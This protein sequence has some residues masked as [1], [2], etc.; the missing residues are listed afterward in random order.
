MFVSIDPVSTV[1]V[2]ILG[3][4]VRKLS[5]TERFVLGQQERSHRVMA[6]VPCKHWGP[7]K[8]IALRR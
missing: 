8:N 2:A 6:L 3:I 4:F 5:N 1:A 7:S